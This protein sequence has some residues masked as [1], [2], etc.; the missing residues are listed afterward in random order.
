MRVDWNR[1]GV[2]RVWDPT[3]WSKGPDGMEYGNKLYEIWEQII[4]SITTDFFQAILTFI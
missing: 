2:Y 1:D 4:W 3:V